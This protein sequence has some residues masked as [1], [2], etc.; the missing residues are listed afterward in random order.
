[1]SETVQLRATYSLASN[2]LIHKQVYSPRTRGRAVAIFRHCIDMLN[3][4]KEEH[5]EA[6]DRFMQPIMSLWT[7]AF[8][9][10]LRHRA[11]G[12]EAIQMAEYGLKMEVVKVG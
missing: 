2:Q 8:L 3:T 6:A 11:Q 12:S 7:E 4:L 1:M 9:G 10:V 5:P